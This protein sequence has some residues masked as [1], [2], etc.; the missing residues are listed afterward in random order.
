MEEKEG[1][2]AEGKGGGG[3]EEENTKRGHRVVV[4]SVS[5]LIQCQCYNGAVVATLVLAGSTEE[6]TLEGIH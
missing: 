1:L 3:G 2:W 5:L 6:C 4:M